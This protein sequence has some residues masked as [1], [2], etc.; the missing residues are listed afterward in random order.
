MS[1]IPI[2]L[3][4][5][6]EHPMRATLAFLVAKPAIDEGSTVTLFLN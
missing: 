2:H 1:K 6:P 3:T 4:H 5:G